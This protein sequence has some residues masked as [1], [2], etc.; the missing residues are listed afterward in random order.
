MTRDR[1][2]A[3]DRAIAAYRRLIQVRA[4]HTTVEMIA[5][6]VEWHKIYVDEKV[7]VTALFETAQRRVAVNEA[8]RDSKAR[9]A[10]PR[11]EM[12]VDPTEWAPMGD[13]TVRAQDL[14]DRI[15]RDQQQAYAAAAETT[16]GLNIRFVPDG[17]VID[18]DRIDD[19]PEF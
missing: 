14:M 13:G 12:P 2:A 6:L 4:Q 1:Q 15:L 17:E 7:D 11:D 18:D 5:D 10:E 19:D 3:I 8:D 16:R 9:T